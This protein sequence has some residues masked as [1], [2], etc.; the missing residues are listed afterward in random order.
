M[1]I[2]LIRH[3]ETPDNKRRILQMPDSNLSDVGIEQARRLAERLADEK[4]SSIVSSDY[5]RT[6]QTAQLL[7]QHH[8][9]EIV[10]E[11]L[12][13]ERHFGDWR[14]K[15]YQEVA[16]DRLNDELAPPGGEDTPTFTSRVAK[17][18]GKIS[19]HASQ[20]KGVTLVVSHGLTCRAILQNHLLL[21]EGVTLP[22]S[23]GNTSLSILEPL[24]EWCITRVN[25]TD[26][27]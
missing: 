13:R 2:Y 24:P 3:G 8:G 7:N 23:L 22:E 5:P 20:Q 19:A 14:G 26:H 4:V 10:A 6:L 15:S 1:T 27:L 21:A 11:P 12:L 16:N 9:L 25:C 18:W 17:A